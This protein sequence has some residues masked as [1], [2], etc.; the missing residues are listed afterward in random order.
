M[1]TT[2][3]TPLVDK[4]SGRVRTHKLSD[5]SY[6]RWLWNNTS[7]SREMGENAYGCADAA[8]I[9]YTIGEFPREQ[10]ERDAFVKTLQAMQDDDGLFHE[11]THH[12]I[13]TTAHCTA[14]L[15]LF[16]A[17]P[18]KRPNA[19]LKYLDT[20]ELYS[21]IESLD[22]AKSPWNASHQGAGIYVIMHL[23]GES[24]S[25]W[26]KKYFEWFW[27]NADSETGFWCGRK[28]TVKPEVELYNYMAGGFHYMF[29]HEYAH[30]PLRYPD[31]VIDSCIW[32]YDEKRLT[33]GFGQGADFINVDWVYCLTRAARQ[34][35]HRYDEVYD[36]LED[37]AE[38][39]L[40]FWFNADWEHNETLNDLHMLFGGVC[41]LAELQ[42][43]LRGKMPS[44]KPLRL[45]LDRRP[46]I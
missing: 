4:I 31:K 23:C 20:D 37:F 14:A 42:S 10:S 5:G 3:I 2:D 19:L 39:H 16:D 1:Q 43:A 7:G 40:D 12:F 33:R 38:K 30:M 25:S 36:R 21:L 13:H 32:M 15:E 45:V 18:A 8:N 26:E 44:R 9:L 17:Q 28:G 22:W 29:N 46:F 6:C 27:D 34:T 35:S 11:K 24:D 41:T